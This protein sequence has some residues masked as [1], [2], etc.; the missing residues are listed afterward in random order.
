VKGVQALGLLLIA[1]GVVYALGY[2]GWL[3]RSHRRATAAGRSTDKGIVT[4]TG[5]AIEPAAASVTE[6]LTEPVT[7]P[8]QPRP[9]TLAWVEGK[10][11]STTTAVS[12]QERVAA[13][14]LGVRARATMVVDDST[15]RWERLGASEVR[16]AGPRVLGVSLG[17]SL[18]GRFPGRAHLVLVTW[19]AD[20]DKNGDR[21]VTGFR[22]RSRADS[23]V[24]VS[25]VQRLM[26]I[27][28]PI[29]DALKTPDGT[30]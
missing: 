2:V 9:L 3:R 1:A 24:L 27:G 19:T 30:L 25:A 11:V 12:R 14:G 29:R 4:D 23:A 26:K 28:G 17:R 7:E 10:Y 13:A 16:V 20:D 5:T 8:A 6:P 18:A 15:V 22:P 21:F